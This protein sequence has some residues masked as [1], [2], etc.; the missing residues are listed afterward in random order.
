MEGKNGVHG[1]IAGEGFQEFQK[2]NKTMGVNREKLTISGKLGQQAV[3]ENHGDTESITSN[4]EQLEVRPFELHTSPGQWAS[5][6][7]AGLEKTTTTLSNQ[8]PNKYVAAP[9]EKEKAQQAYIFMA[10]PNSKEKEPDFRTAEPGGVKINQVRNK[11]SVLM[12]KRV[13][14]VEGGEID[15]TGT[16]P[17]IM[18]KRKAEV[19]GPNS[20][21]QR[22]LK[23][24]KW[25]DYLEEETETNFEDFEIQTETKN[26]TAEAAMQPRPQP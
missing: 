18:G 4:A 15:Q 12:W 13:T 10:Q 21:D 16:F 3:H 25:E 14:Q 8:R 7:G 5:T 1:G 9:T 6:E 19:G 11:N 26:E 23:I 2:G 17:A 24:R 22:H 20:E